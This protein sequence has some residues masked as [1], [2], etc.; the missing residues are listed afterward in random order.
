M[1]KRYHDSKMSHSRSEQKREK[2]LKHKQ[3]LMGGV[4]M[5]ADDW[6]AP[7]LLP[8]NVIDRNWP[9]NHVDYMG[10]HID[11]LFTGVQEQL[12]EDAADLRRE[13]EP[14]KY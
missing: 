1:P 6:A 3:H 10:G 7:A 11:D 9:S 4:G 14:K 2:H 8:R 13:M 12:G 5:I